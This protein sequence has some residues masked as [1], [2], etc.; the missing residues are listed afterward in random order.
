MQL[1]DTG[2]REQFRAI[3]PAYYRDAVGGLLVFDITNRQSLDNL[4]VWLKD[5]QKYAGPYKPVFILVGNKTD[6]AIYRKVSKEAAL[7]FAT[8]HD[9]DYYETSA[10]NGS[11]VEEVFHKLTDKILTLV[12]GEV[13]K[14]EEGWRGV[15]RGKEL[16]HTLSGRSYHIGRRY[17]TSI[18][19]GELSDDDRERNK[20]CCCC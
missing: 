11:N 4:S 15:K 20:G 5:A 8:Q 9:M 10:M 12:D 6:Q 7:S 16:S 3:S 1:W 2:G 17:S 19:L 18:T 14:I 13:I